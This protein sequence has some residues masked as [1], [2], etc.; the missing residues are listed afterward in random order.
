MNDDARRVYRRFGDFFLIV[1]GIFLV[2][3]LVR[4]I[5]LPDLLRGDPTQVAVLLL[6]IGGGLRWTVRK[7]PD[8]EDAEDAEDADAGEGEPDASDTS[9]AAR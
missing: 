7:R 2:I 6:A 1:G 4:A 5:F 3:G 9:D 8:D